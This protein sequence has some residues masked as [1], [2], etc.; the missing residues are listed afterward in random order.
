L[1]Q[2]IPRFSGCS[3]SEIIFFGAAGEV[4]K[5]SSNAASKSS[6]DRVSNDEDG[7]E[8]AVASPFLSK[9]AA[10]TEP[11]KKK[12]PANRN[13]NMRVSIKIVPES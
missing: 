8:T 13:M 4:E 1:N 7:D 6:S 9:F 3:G 10:K 5:S 11:R 12:Y 2:K